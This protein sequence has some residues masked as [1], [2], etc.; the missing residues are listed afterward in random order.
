MLTHGVGR[1]SKRG[2]RWRKHSPVAGI[3]LVSNVR[4]RNMP[5]HLERDDIARFYDDAWR[6][7]EDQA[8][9]E[10]A[11]ALARRKN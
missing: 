8:R 7:A 6:R 5:L 1:R 2:K 4:V 11:E 9:R 10:V 3:A